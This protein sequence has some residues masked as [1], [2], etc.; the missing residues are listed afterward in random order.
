M[1]EYILREAAKEELLSWARCINHPEHLMTADAMCV[2]DDIPAAEVEPVVHARWIKFYRTFFGVVVGEDTVC[3]NCHN[4]AEVLQAGGGC[5]FT[6]PRCPY[7]GAH[8]GGEL[9]A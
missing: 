1:A 2:L 6:P 3:S 5:D 4:E 7:C 8:M 9:D